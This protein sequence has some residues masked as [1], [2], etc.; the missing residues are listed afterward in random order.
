M[1]NPKKPAGKTSTN[2]S[3]GNKSK[4]TSSNSSVKI[5]EE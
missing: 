4:V 3:S 2:K 1:A 5:K